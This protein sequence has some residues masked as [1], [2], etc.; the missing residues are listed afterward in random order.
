M[1]VGAHWAT[2]V[3]GS[4]HDVEF[5]KTL[6]F[7]VSSLLSGPSP[8]SPSPLPPHRA[9]LGDQV[10]HVHAHNEY[11][12]YTSSHP[13]HLLALTSSTVSPGT[14]L[15]PHTVLLYLL[16]P[17]HP[18]TCIYTSHPHTL[19]HA[20]LPPEY[21]S[22]LIALLSAPIHLVVT[23]ATEVLPLPYRPPHT[24][25]PFPLHLW[26]VSGRQWVRYNPAQNA[27]ELFLKRTKFPLSVSSCL[28][29][30]DCFFSYFASLILSSPFFF[31]FSSPSKF[32]FPLSLFSPDFSPFPS[33]FLSSLPP[34]PLSSPSPSSSLLP[35]GVWKWSHTGCLLWFRSEC[36]LFLWTGGGTNEGTARG[37][38]GRDSLPAVCLHHNKEV[39]C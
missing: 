34:P 1:Y 25:T 21:L 28:R 11:R 8:S 3:P 35:G 2:D 6:Y 9:L 12:Q 19:P 16:T 10:T 32:S 36:G 13:P 31:F 38:A 30:G 15:P 22:L 33:S 18:P 39:S 37:R 24:I 20:H 17:S 29:H 23:M 26:F 5:S 27:L 14:P 4:Q 7:A